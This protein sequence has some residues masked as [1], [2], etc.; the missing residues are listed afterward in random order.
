M[1]LHF[2]SSLFQG[3]GDVRDRIL[4]IY[5]KTGEGSGKCVAGGAAFVWQ[6]IQ[7]Y[8]YLDLSP[9][10]ID[11]DLQNALSKQ[12]IRVNVPSRFTVAISNE[13]GVINNAARKAFGKN[14]TGDQ[15]YCKG[16]NI[17][18]VGT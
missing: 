13:P 17:R 18:S 10:S 6:V 9:I 12:N 3:T 14:H 15:R 2:Y 16:Y 4:V 1:Q 8:E 5:G 7:D 11:V